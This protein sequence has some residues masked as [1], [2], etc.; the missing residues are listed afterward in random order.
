VTA[1]PRPVLQV[2]VLVSLALVLVTATWCVF[3][4]LKIG[5][6]NAMESRT[7]GAPLPI[8]SL[9]TRPVMQLEFVRGA[10]DVKAILEVGSTNQSRNV[11]DVRSGNDLDSTRLIP[12]YMMLLIALSLLIAQGSRNVGDL[13]FLVGIT[14]AMLI[15]GADLIE[16]YGIGRILD[17]PGDAALTD[18]MARLVSTAAFVKWTLLGLILIYLGVV[19]SLPQTW[20][21]WLSPVLLGLGIVL[22]ATIGRHAVERFLT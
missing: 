20:R 15:A 2:P 4:I 5:P 3:A 14:M 18:R 12:G 1:Q 22:L 16:N 11:E 7:K 21:R 8:A 13:L 6:L 10:Q 9:P 19:A 17:A